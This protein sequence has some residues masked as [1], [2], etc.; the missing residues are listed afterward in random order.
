MAP[1]ASDPLL[2]A[3][4]RA[5]PDRVARRREPGSRRALMVGG[6]GVRLADESAVHDAE[7]FLCIDVEGAG[8]EALVRQASAIEREWLPPQ[9][10]QEVTECEFDAASGKVIARRRVY[11]SDLL[12]A[13]AP[14]AL[15]DADAVAQALAH[16]AAERLADV[17]PPADSVAGHFRARVQCLREWMP[18]LGLPPLDDA[19]LGALLPQLARGRR[20]LE[21]LRA[22]PWLAAMQDLL[23]WPQRQAV[24][25]EAPERI[26]VPSGSRIAIQYERG[27]PPIL[28]VRFQEVFG[29]AETPRIAGG[30]VPVLLHLLAPSMRVAQVTGDLAGFWAG[31]YAQVRKDLKARYPKHAWPDDPARAV[32][33]RRP[34]RRP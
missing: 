28:A 17:M 7:L 18:E 9:R 29:L 20:S 5:Y 23:T 22:A 15:P 32:P 16:A 19:Q 1:A 21:E 26:A 11:Y 34:G 6:P 25:R 12:L 31:T 10:V 27:R 2:V 33:Q 8:S 3:L 14:A 30:R 4:L 13:E 24:E